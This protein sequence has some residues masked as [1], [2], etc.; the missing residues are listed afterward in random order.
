[1][2]T[3]TRATLDLDDIQRGVLH[4]RPT[5]YV[6]TYLLLRVD[7]RRVGR[8]MLRRLVPVVD[9]AGD[10]SSPASEAWVSVAFTFQGLKAFGVPQDSLDS[11][12]PEFQ[13]G[14]AARADLLGDVGE[15]SPAH[16]VH[17][18]GTPDSHVLVSIISQ[19]E[20]RRDALLTQAW[21]AYGDVTGVSMIYRQDA[22][23]LLGGREPFGFKDGISHPA[24]E[25]SPI[26]G[27]NHH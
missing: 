25:G 5:P 24:V 2:V 9:A 22:Q 23:V 18:V 19:D 1:M 4:D 16:W 14:M 11:F 17:P 13:Q 10:L 7:D 3:E 8:E 27:S 12:A 6:A 20:P 21:R 26:P 15:S